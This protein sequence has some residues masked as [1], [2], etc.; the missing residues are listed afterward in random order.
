[1]CFYIKIHFRLNNHHTAEYALRSQAPIRQISRVVF[2]YQINKNFRD[3]DFE[4]NHTYR[5]SITGY[6]IRRIKDTEN[7]T[8]IVD[9]ASDGVINKLKELN[10]KCNSEDVSI[11]N[12]IKK[13][14]ISGYTMYNE[15]NNK[16]LI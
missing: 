6:V 11:D 13:M 2:G 14:K 12:N 10:F 7:T 3:S 4:R 15:I 1:M 16:L 8:Q 5:V 9:D